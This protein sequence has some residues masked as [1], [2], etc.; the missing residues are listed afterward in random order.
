M[1]VR[2]SG[3][4]HSAL[5]V[6]LGSS[7]YN[8]PRLWL[9]AEEKIMA[10]QVFIVEDH[11]VMRQGYISLITAQMDLQVCGVT[12]SVGEAR[13]CIPETKPDL[14]IVDLFLE[15]GSGLELI[16]DLRAAQPHL[17]ILV[18]SMHDEALYANRVLRAGARGYV[19]KS[20][21]GS[22][23][24]QA[25]RQILEGRVVLSKEL[26]TQILLRYTGAPSEALRSPLDPLS[27]RELEVFE[28]VGQGY[29]TREIADQL[30]LSPKT[31]S[32]YQTRIKEKLVI[33]TNAEL[34]RRAVIWIERQS[35]SARTRINET[36]RS[37]SFQE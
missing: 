29:S 17:P 33:E 24:L 6:N 23:I 7:E 27:D 4:L 18:V 34:Q 28:Y 3:G 36:S 10:E 14:V 21:D 13:R 20:E 2:L 22:K 8:A 26:S 15:D 31:V 16:K 11:P 19:M 37:V 32:S 9:Q 1:G 5:Y 25:I 35:H 12:G 30:T